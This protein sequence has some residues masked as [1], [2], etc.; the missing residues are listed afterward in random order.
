MVVSHH[1]IDCWELNSGHL[2]EHPEPLSHFSSPNKSFFKK[3]NE[4]EK[5]KYPQ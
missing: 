5:M 1:V 4:R 2:K 3:A